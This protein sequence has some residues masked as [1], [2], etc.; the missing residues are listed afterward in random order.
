MTFAYS[1]IR[2][3]Y[4]PTNELQRSKRSRCGAALYMFLNCNV[5][6]SNLRHPTENN[7]PKLRSLDHIKYLFSFA[8]RQAHSE[9]CNCHCNTEAEQKTKQGGAVCK[10]R[11]ALPNCV[12]NVLKMLIY[13]S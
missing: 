1:S 11:L 4:F 8:R 13:S 12:E 10:S 5:R 7:L 9:L 2:E 6:I 3:L